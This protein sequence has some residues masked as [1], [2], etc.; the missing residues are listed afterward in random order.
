MLPHDC[1]RA[2]IN[3]VIII[4]CMQKQRND[5][6]RFSSFLKV[7]QILENFACLARDWSLI[8]RLTLK[9]PVITSYQHIYFSKHQRSEIQKSNPI[10]KTT[11]SSVLYGYEMWSF[12]VTDTHHLVIHLLRAVKNINCDTKSTSQIFGGLCLSCTSRTCRSPTH[13]QV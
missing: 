9:M 4:S 8:R 1:N 11:L 7:F 10:Y 13:H 5:N 6:F 12:V 3:F 2:H